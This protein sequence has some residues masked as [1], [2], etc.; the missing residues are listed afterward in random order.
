MPAQ[1]RQARTANQPRPPRR[2]RQ[3]EAPRF[4]G[5][6]K[7][8]A[9]GPLRR[10]LLAGSRSASLAV[11]A[12]QK[13]GGRRQDRNLPCDGQRLTAKSTANTADRWVGADED[14]RWPAG[15]GYGG[16][17]WAGPAVVDGRSWPGRP[18]RMARTLRRTTPK[19]PVRVA[20][21]RTRL[22]P[23][24][25]APGG[26]Q[27]PEELPRPSRVSLERVSSYDPKAA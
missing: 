18:V 15:T 9:S 14:E 26:H 4:L 2:S 19:S 5:Y 27:R 16:C 12:R 13:R 7:V 6:N 8:K 24:D 17:C 22:L 25:W 21:G 11:P 3:T 10:A 20:G 1:A 23:A